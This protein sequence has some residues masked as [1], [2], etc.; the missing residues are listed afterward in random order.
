MKRMMPAAATSRRLASEDRP[1]SATTDFDKYKGNPD[2]VLSLARG[3]AVIE[4]FE[5]STGGVS[6]SEI[7]R[8]TGFS[9]AAV[10]RLL[11]TLESLGYAETGG[12]VYNLKTSVL[13]LGFSYLSSA[14]LPGMAQPLAERLSEAV[15]ESSSVSV[16]DADEIVY[17]ARASA[18]RVMSIGLS[19]GSRLP[20][21]CTSM[22]R[23]LLAALPE[24]VFYSYLDH[25]ELKRMTPRT[26]TDKSRFADIISEVRSNGFALADQELEL[27]LRSVAVPIRSRQGRIVAA[28]NIGVQAQ[29][30]SSSEL[31]ENFLPTLR[32]N[33]KMFGDVLP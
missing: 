1:K 19:I 5:G 12:R 3:L 24:T 22:G 29:R 16:L 10:R 9:R 20:A 8:H 11:V 13:K 2:F 14:S 33:A 4:A 15:H 17:L 32:E 6:P 31:L 30:I 28:L 21:Y 27:G 7:A 18:K 26:V 25:V 23:V